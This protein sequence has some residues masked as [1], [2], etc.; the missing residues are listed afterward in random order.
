MGIIFTLDNK[1]EMIKRIIAHQYEQLD[2][3]CK[4]TI[5]EIDDLSLKLSDTDFSQRIEIQRTRELIAS[6]EKN[7]EVKKQEIQRLEIRNRYDQLIRVYEQ[8]CEEIQLLEMLLENSASNKSGLKGSNL[9]II[10][11]L[12]DSNQQP[13]LASSTPDFG[14]LPPNQRLDLTG[15]TEQLTSENQYSHVLKKWQESLSK[16]DSIPKNEPVELISP[17]PEV[18]ILPAFEEPIPVP[19][20]IP[21]VPS[22]PV[23]P[24]PI[25]M[26]P[27]VSS[28]PEAQPVVLEVPVIP[29]TPTLL[30]VEPSPLAPEIPVSLPT[31][32][33]E[34]ELL[35]ELPVVPV[36]P[37]PELPVMPVVPA[38]ELPVMPVAPAQELPV[39]P[40]VPAPELP[41]MP[42]PVVEEAPPIPENATAEMAISKPKKQ[43]ESKQKNKNQ[44]K[45]KKQ[46]Y[47]IDPNFVPLTKAEKSAG[48]AIN[49]F[50]A[51]VLVIAVVFAILVNF[52]NAEAIGESSELFGNSF[53]VMTS[54]IM[55]STAPPG[56]I[57]VV[58]QDVEV[59][60]MQIGDF[61]TF[62]RPN[63][64]IVAGHIHSIYPDFHGFGIDGI[65]LIG[66]P[67]AT[68]GLPEMEVHRAD[69]FVGEVTFSNLIIGMLLQFGYH[70][71]AMAAMFLVCV[72]AFL[73]LLKGGIAPKPKKIKVKE[74]SKSDHDDDEK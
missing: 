67:Q 36:V 21:I 58:N 61:V 26:V 32:I 12:N 52:V 30:P 13:K 73:V 18:T 53:I 65:R 40:V 39:M 38:Q 28:I 42:I 41:V 69:A 29:E 50:F 47:I 27:E 46:D 37:A 33:P 71:T 24:Q 62:M 1:Q 57:L 43:K 74:S 63:E 49:G 7:V 66:E 64:A 3:M 6:I 34:P 10:K 23:E 31:L 72:L 51:L 25:P 70:Y 44:K 15:T 48:M 4:H 54:D 22:L 16:I 11:N 56:S 8:T 45:S 14:V 17:E 59:A 2:E 35:P 19:Q 60:T 55:P 20:P 9:E 5:A 68:G